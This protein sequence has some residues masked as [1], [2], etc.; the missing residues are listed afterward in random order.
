MSFVVAIRFAKVNNVQ[1]WSWDIDGWMI[2]TG[3]MCAAA[4]ALLGNFL[5]LRRMSLLGDAISH[6]VLPG[7][8]AAF[9]LTGQRQG[10]ALFV[11]AAAVG[12]LT[13]LLTELARRYGRVDEGAA[14]GVVFTGLFALGL[15]LINVEAAKKVDLDAGCVLYGSLEMAVFDRVEIAGFQVPRVALPLATV[16]LLNIS[17]VIGLYRP[18]KVST[19]DPQL[20][21]SQ[22]VYVAA[23][24]YALAAIVAVT[25]VASFESVGNI[26]VVAMFV[27][28]PVTAWMLTDR[29][30]VMIWLSVLIA[31]AS[32]ILGHVAAFTVPY[33][34]GGALHVVARGAEVATGH[35]PVIPALGKAN[36]AGM[37]TVIAGGLLLL[38]VFIAPRKGILSRALKSMRVALSILSEDVLATVYRAEA[39]G[40]KGVEPRVLQSSLMVSSLR[41]WLAIRWLK[42][43]GLLIAQGQ[44]LMLAEP[45]RRRAQ[46]IV[47]AHRLWEQYLAAETGFSDRELHLGAER[48]EHF[49]DKQLRDRL[50]AE[51]KSPEVDPHGRPIPPEAS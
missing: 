25:A 5:V 38:A 34:L 21:A 50:D 7:L 32:A 30:V 11:G 12:V 48:F 9:I 3:A 23:I 51:T 19:F 18:L 42:Y 1:D 28:P 49:T 46:N 47:R 45:G 44:Q 35:S 40:A 8:A 20:A 26:L 6:A 37:M 2:A 13:V 15:L 22:G 4:A 36:T 41:S 17:F 10:V 14:I 33:W 29:L 39:A 31:I 27:V 24:H 16:L 43:Q